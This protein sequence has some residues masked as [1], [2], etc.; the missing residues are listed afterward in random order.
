RAEAAPQPIA[1]PRCRRGQGVVLER[2]ADLPLGQRDLLDLALAQQG[3]ELAQ[4]D[5]DRAGGDEPPLDDEQDRE[6]DEQI[7][8]GKLR[9]MAQWQFH[10]RLGI[11]LTETPRAVKLTDG[12]RQTKRTHAC[13]KHQNAATT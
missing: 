6:D 13:A 3:D 12:K 11:M 10:P 9:L 1:G 4:R 2:A 7:K 8:Q 5:L